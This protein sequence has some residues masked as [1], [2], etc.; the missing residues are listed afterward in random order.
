MI[1]ISTQAEMRRRFAGGEPWGFSFEDKSCLSICP[2]GTVNIFETVPGMNEIHKDKAPARAVTWLEE[3]R[4]TLS[5]ILDEAGN[6][7]W[8]PP[9]E[10]LKKSRHIMAADVTGDPAMTD[11]E[12]A[13][14]R[15]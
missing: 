11:N 15:G 5:R 14:K 9:H 4:K 12:G 7:G 2:D 8:K 1:K 3:H 13:A 10:S 6:R